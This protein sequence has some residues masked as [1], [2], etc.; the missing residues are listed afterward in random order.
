MKIFGLIG[1][2]LEHSFSPQYFKDK[3]LQI[4][5]ENAV[6]HAFPL[7]SINELHELLTNNPGLTGLNVTIPYKNQVIPFLNELDPAAQLVNAVNTIHITKSG[8]RNYLKG[9]NTDVIGFKASLIPLL[10]KKHYKALILG[11]GGASKAVTYVLSQMNIPYTMVSRNPNREN[12]LKYSEVNSATMSTHLLII[13]CTPVGMYPD[14]NCPEIPYENL[15]TQHILY[16]LIYNPVRT[17]FLQQG[18]TKGAKI[19]NGLEMLHLQAD[20]SWEIWNQ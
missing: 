8:D 16:D 10:E 12:Q 17:M 9:Y 2:P 5:I 15:T 3:F 18:E 13:N 19:K 1:Y 6:Y 11:T 20:A 7:Q 14:T 4:G